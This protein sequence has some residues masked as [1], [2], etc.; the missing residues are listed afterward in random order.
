MPDQDQPSQFIDEI[1]KRTLQI[2]SKDPA[3]D[4]HTLRK[5]EQL[6][7]SSELADYRKIVDALRIEEEK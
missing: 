3:F 7:R 6:A 1:V 2:L 5:L 4:D